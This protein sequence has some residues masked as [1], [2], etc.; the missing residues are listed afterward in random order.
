MA[1]TLSRH[2]GAAIMWL[3]ALVLIVSGLVA[4][5]SL[6]EWSATLT[7]YVLIGLLWRGF[8]TLD[9]ADMLTRA[10]ATACAVLLGT[11]ALSQLLL[12][13]E[14]ERLGLT[15]APVPDNT[16]GLIIVI[17]GRLAVLGLIIFWPHWINRFHGSD[18][19]W[20]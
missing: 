10:L 5:H 8:S 15:G 14:I 17:L 9:H 11:G 1:T 4:D 20:A 18:R 12:S 7:L 2:S 19:S 3:T 6:R 16:A 13:R